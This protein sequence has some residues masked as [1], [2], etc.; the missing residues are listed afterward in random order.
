VALGRIGLLLAVPGIAPACGD[1][2]HLLGRVA[3]VGDAAAVSD[4][5]SPDA[6]DGGGR[7]DAGPGD[8]V[9]VSCPGLGPPVQ[10]PTATGSVCAAALATRR[11]RFALCLCDSLSVTARINTDTFDSS[12]GSI[13]AQPPAAIGIDGD[14]QS[15]ARI[16]ALG[17]V[18]VAGAGGLTV[19]D[20]LVSLG[21]L[22]VAGPMQIPGGVVDVAE[23]VY[24]GGSI[25]GIILVSGTLFVDPSASTA[26][27]D[28]SASYTVRQPVSVA[29]PCDCGPNV[30]D[31]A[32]A[33]AA[34][35]THNDDAVAGFGPDRLAAVTTSTVLD[36][37]CGTYALSSIDTQQSLFL[38][39]HG[40]ALL[41][42]AGDVVLRAGFTVALDPGAELDLLVGGR[43]L[44]SGSNA[45]GSQT[46]ARFRI[47]VAGS[48]SVVLDDDPTVG[49]VIHAAGA[50]VTASSGL[51]LSG[52]L[53][54]KTLTAGA[55]VNVH[56]DQAVL[57]A[58][59]TCGEPTATPVP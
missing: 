26:L 38:A 51:E 10:L 29:P 11:H 2:G 4:G 41:A 56:Y 28:I 3:G 46:P 35:A 55:Q 15:S 17:S 59:T 57:S 27:A 19:S 31:V 47:W 6:S 14:L 18:Y 16:Q 53:L 20:L 33:I 13:G 34:A 8:G 40:R 58:G 52:G 24:A 45:I 48:Q 30:V 54:A 12:G 1:S 5:A 50:Q 9:P 43:L 25:Q 39:V 21:S 37:P 49:A 7:S 22:H 42:V 44:T 36:V 23:D 32:G